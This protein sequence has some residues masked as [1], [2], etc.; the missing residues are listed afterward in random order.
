[1]KGL[2]IKDLKFLKN[3]KIFLIVVL[4]ISIYFFVTG[5]NTSFVL[6]YASAMFA[7]LAI[8]TLNYDE[9][10]NGMSYLLTFPI[11]RKMY[12]LEKYLFGGL[13][14]VVTVF[15][16]G[17]FISGLVAAKSMFYSFEEI[18][19]YLSAALLIP[20]VMLSVMLPILIKFGAEKGRVA[21][22]AVLGIVIAA[23][24]SIK[25]VV[26]ILGID[27]LAK[28]DQWMQADTAITVAGIIVFAAGLF[29]VSYMISMAIMKRKQF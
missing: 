8:S 2:L 10:D 12:V 18:A 21:M 1:M 14:A 3:Q 13:M 7:T 28:M 17:L 20:I 6:G 4:A 9:Q 19:M 22:L 26:D 16:E 15:V 29:V 5:E 27:I 11:S 25:M 24:Y 23:G